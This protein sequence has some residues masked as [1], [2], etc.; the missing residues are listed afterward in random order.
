MKQR[1]LIQC[2]CPPRLGSHKQFILL[3]LFFSEDDIILA[4][5]DLW[6]NCGCTWLLGCDTCL[7][8][9]FVPG[10]A[11]I[12]HFQ[13]IF[14]TF[15]KVFSPLCCSGFALWGASAAE[16]FEHHSSKQK[17]GVDYLRVVQPSVLKC[18]VPAGKWV[19]F[20]RSSCPSGERMNSGFFFTSW[21]LFLVSRTEVWVANAAFVQPDPARGGNG[22]QQRVTHAVWRQRGVLFLRP[23]D[24]F[25]AL[26]R[27]NCWGSSS[28]ASWADQLLFFGRSTVNLQEKLRSEI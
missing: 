28:F 15:S 3:F 16:C 25:E 2:N 12:Y 27:T 14:D 8:K 20:T 24:T 19:L 7:S 6:R 5:N 1:Q 26:F 9:C 22:K 11:N 10:Y 18:F 21:Y 23:Y 13:A 17:P 4:F